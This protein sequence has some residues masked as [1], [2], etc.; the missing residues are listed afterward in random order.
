MPFPILRTP[1]VVLSEIISILEPSEIVT[2]S[3]CSKNVNRL[4][5]RHY[6]QRKPLEWKLVLDYHC[7]GEVYIITKQ[8]PDDLR[9]NQRKPVL[10]I[11]HISQARHESEHKLIETNEYKRGFTSKLPVLYFEDQVMGSKMIVDYAS[12]LF[13]LDIYG[14]VI[15]RDC[16]WAIDWIN[17]RQEKMLVY[18]NFMKNKCNCNGDEAM[19]N[20]LRKALASDYIILKD[21]V[22]DTYRFDGKLGP[23]GLLFIESYGHWVTL[24]NLINFDFI[25]IMIDESRLSVSDLNSFLRHWRAG[26]LPR[27]AFLA[28][29]CK[30]STIFE[31]FDE[32]LQAVETD[33]VVQYRLSYGKKLVFRNGYSIQR[34]DGVKATIKG[35]IGFFLM[36]VWHE[37]AVDSA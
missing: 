3:F 36:A 11:R 10:L 37:R 21:I 25:E 34:M 6:Q 12:D 23:A 4:L 14:L 24:D 1:F 33:E 5:K 19:D 35:Y 18:F 22:S 30:T 20:V 27:L 8:Q 2:A 7:W 26:G 29:K 28:L 15:D 16:I 32:D 9:K 17:N 13:N 31:N